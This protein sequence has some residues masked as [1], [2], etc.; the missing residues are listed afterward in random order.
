MDYPSFLPLPTLASWTV[1]N[2]N[3]TVNSQPAAGSS[4][5]MVVSDDLIEYYDAT[6]TLP[7]VYAQAF[8]A[9]VLTDTYYI[10][11]GGYFNMPIATES[12]IVTKLC[13]FIAG[14][15]PQLVSITRG[16]ATYTAKIKVITPGVS[17]GPIIPTPS[18]GY[19]ITGYIAEGY[20]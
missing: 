2:N 18:D 19:F 20:I 17:D 5:V 9:W 10:E 12:G 14:S 8:R 16:V 13:A 7:T 6:F 4:F 3:R 15:L 1:N 11:R